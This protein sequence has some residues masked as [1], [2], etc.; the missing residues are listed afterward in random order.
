M[1]VMFF[2]AKLGGMNENTGSV[3]MSEDKQSAENVCRRVLQVANVLQVSSTDLSTSNFAALTL[4]SS[5]MVLVQVILTGS[6]AKVFVNSEK[7]VIG[8][9]LLKDL[10]R[11]LSQ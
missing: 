1:I 6:K 8:T 3:E 7:M 9:M 2:S 10:K 4:S 5:T 11:T